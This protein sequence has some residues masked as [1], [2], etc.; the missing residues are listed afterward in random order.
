MLPDFLLPFKHYHEEIIVDALDD[1]LDPEL[2]DDRPSDQ[3]IKHWKYWIFI[4]TSNIDGYI[5]SIAY[6]EL[7]FS[8]ELLQSGISLLN[9]LR[10][11][12]PDG[13]LKTVIRIIYNAGGFL[14]ALYI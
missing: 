4:N 13:W 1:R 7:D 11:S 6:R 12:I 8:E 3:T 5:K 14:E 10:S 9:K 2:L